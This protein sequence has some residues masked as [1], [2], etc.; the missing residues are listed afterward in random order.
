[1]GETPNTPQVPG[2]TEPSEPRIGVD[3]W[4]A[5]S[6]ERIQAYAGV[7]GR[8][9]RWFD[10]I[11]VSLRF[12]ALVA[13]VALVPV[14][15]SNQYFL[16]VGVVSL[17]YAL[18]ALGLNVSV[19]LAGLLDLGY[20]AFYGVGAYG[21]A[22]LSS[23]KFGVHWPTWAALPVVLAASVVVGFLLALPSRRLVGDYL[24]IVTLFFGQIFYTIAVQG[25]RVPLITIQ[26]SHDLTGGP[27]GIADVDGFRFF[28]HRLTTNQAYFWASLIAVAAVFVA[29][30]LMNESRTGRAWRALRD[31]PLATELMGMPVNWLKLL[32]I[33]VGA[34][35]GALAGTINVASLHGAFPD[36]YSTPILIT[37]YAMVI[38]GG[39]GNLFGV[40]V[41]AVSVNLLLEV[42]RTPEHA[43]WILYVAIFLGLVAKLR[44][45]KGLVAVLAGTAAFG[46]AVHAI[47]AAA[48]PRGVHGLVSIS[49]TEFGEGGW[50]GW[51]LRHWLVL[52][53]NTYAAGRYTIFNFAF[54][55]LIGLVLALTVV[56]RRVRWLLLVPTLWLAAFVW[57][58]RLVEEGTGPTRFLLLGAILVVLM[59]ARPQGLLG[60]HRVEIA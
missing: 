8:V 11:P 60:T 14:M 17:I 59:A 41:G 19:G 3:E 55:L 43:R 1:M 39:V 20:V 24:A 50:L 28:G 29:I 22:M 37:I 35:A 30:H 53:A 45:W 33:A 7:T 42:L 21:Y 31:D 54:V 48:W 26:G 6:G 46:I 58:T 38:L 51:A 15:T 4:V 23:S 12:V 5:S 18:L 44:P 9:R 16:R 47:V 27:N 10:R 57:E 52:P 34:G 32:A 49:G 25:Y 40:V 2:T 56:R 36:D 13:V